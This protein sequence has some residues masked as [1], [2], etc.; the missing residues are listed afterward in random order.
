MGGLYLALAA[1]SA[2][3][4][5]MWPRLLRLAIPGVALATW[6]G[7]AVV[8]WAKPRFRYFL[9]FTMTIL[10]AL[11]LVTLWDAARSGRKRAEAAR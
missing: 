5:R 6:L 10:V 1:A 2:L 9:D 4:W 11:V 7:H 8:F 3:L